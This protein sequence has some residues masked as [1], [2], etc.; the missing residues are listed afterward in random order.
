MWST[1]FYLGTFLGPTIAGFLV[2]WK[3]FRFSTIPSF[4]LLIVILCVDLVELVY[5]IKIKRSTKNNN[6]QELTTLL[7]K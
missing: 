7:E 3:G 2:E 1:A 4:V 5:N 6:N